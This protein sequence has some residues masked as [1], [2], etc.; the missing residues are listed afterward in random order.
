MT[1]NLLVQEEGIYRVTYDDIAA[2][3]IDLSGVPSAYLALTNMGEPVRIR[4]M[5]A[6]NVQGRPTWGPGAYFEFIGEGIETLYTKDNVYVLQVD[7]S[8]AFRTFRNMRKPNRNQDG[9][10]FLHRDGP[11]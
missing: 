9:A 4:M 10:H 2:K 11:R 1:V 8:K 3:G 5:S 6:P 7:R